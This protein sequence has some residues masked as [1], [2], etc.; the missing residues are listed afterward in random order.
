MGVEIETGFLC[1]SV[2]GAEFEDPAEVRDTLERGNREYRRRHG[3]MQ[4]EEI[5]YLR[6]LY[7]LTQRELARLLGWGL[8]T[9]SRYENGALQDAAHDKTLQ[10]MREPQNLLRLLELGV[11]A[12]DDEKRRGIITRFQDSRSGVYGMAR[13]YAERFGQ[14]EADP[15]SGYRRLDMVKLLNA[16]LFFCED[17]LAKTSVHKI[18]FFADFKHFKEYAGSIT[19]ARYLKTES[20][21]VP[22]KWHYYLTLL[23]ERREL[24]V[25][26]VL[27]AEDI[28]GEWLS[29]KMKPDLALFNNSELLILA[30]VK[31]HFKSWN[32]KKISNLIRNER[33]YTETPDRGIIPYPLAADLGI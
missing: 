18:L 5:R 22:E 26:E 9:V 6:K 30:F 25:K 15:L 27:A 29:S 24:D 7:G 21:P 2:C 13:I 17:G 28:A 19:G 31:D 8:A 1:C 3:M 23:I 14:Y 11:E 4:P 16:V 10:L 32:A 33:G 12:L 20:G